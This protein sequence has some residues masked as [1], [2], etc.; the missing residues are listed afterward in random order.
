MPS[1]FFRKEEVKSSA[2]SEEE[3]RISEVFK[4]RMSQA[5]VKNRRR[6]FTR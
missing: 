4:C 5:I 2:A 3:L 6:E 1:I